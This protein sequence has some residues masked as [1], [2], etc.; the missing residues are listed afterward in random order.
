MVICDGFNQ[1]LPKSEHGLEQVN[2]HQVT[3]G[4]VVVKSSPFPRPPPQPPARNSANLNL[5]V[6]ETNGASLSSS[7]ASTTSSASS[8][9]S[10]GHSDTDQPPE[11]PAKPA[12]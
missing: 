11:Q 1:L 4:P 10:N 6:H 7:S 9:S 2:G 8:T 3:N 12:G 5:V